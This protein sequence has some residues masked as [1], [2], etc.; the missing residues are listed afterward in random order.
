MTVASMVVLSAETKV[1]QRV[2][3]MV[4][5]TVDSMVV[6]WA[7]TKVAQRVV[8]MVDLTVETKVDS[9]TALMAE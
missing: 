7:E 8:V 5:L 1:A 3:V 4:D 2:V 6:L 9:M